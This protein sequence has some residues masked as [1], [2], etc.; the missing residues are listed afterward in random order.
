MLERTAHVLEQLV[1]LAHAERHEHALVL[2]L[3]QAA[4]EGLHVRASHMLRVLG[5]RGLDDAPTVG[6]QVRDDARILDARIL[7]LD[8]ENAAPVPDIVIEP[9]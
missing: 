6:K 1:E 7:G 4:H 5:A 2:L 8:V 9:E 3:H